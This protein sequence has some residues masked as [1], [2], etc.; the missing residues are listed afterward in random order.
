MNSDVYILGFSAFPGIGTIRFEQLINEFGTPEKAW[1]ASRS[2]LI[3]VLKEAV[4]TQ[5]DEFRKDFNLKK[6]AEEVEQKHIHYFIPQD[7]EY[8]KLLRQ[9]SHPPFI[10][11]AK[12]N[13]NVLQE[14][15]TIGIV[16][17]RKVTDYGQQ[18]TEMLVRDLVAQGFTIVSGMALG[19]DGVAHRETI[20]NGG[21]T[22]AVLGSGVDFPTPREHSNLY[23]DILENNGLIVS[24]F[25]PGEVPQKGSFPARNATIAG[26]SQ[27]IVVTEGAESSGALI[28]ANYAKK[29]GRP[30]FSV[31]GQIT[32]QLSIGTNNLIKQGAIA[33]SSVQDIL[34][35]V[36]IM[37]VQKT[38]KLGNSDSQNIR[39]SDNPDELSILSILEQNGPLHFDEIV[40]TIGKDSRSVG[41]I[42]SLMELKGMTKSGS[43]GKYFINEK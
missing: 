7:K 11:F 10:L 30:V 25:S 39:K 8:P 14:E 34:D 4:G 5:F 3:S 42:L 31:P 17:T 2:D 26:F 40:R 32:S 15:K 1:N 37:T 12:G 35:S 19:V 18:V 21:S 9:L 23:T 20:K 33:V 24:T 6:Y 36:G 22:I 27:G 41:S 29:F 28:T 13:R 43:D 16:G 38:Q